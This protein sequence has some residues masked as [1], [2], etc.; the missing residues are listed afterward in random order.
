[1]RY[2][3]FGFHNLKKI[4]TSADTSFGCIFTVV[5]AVCINT[6]SSDAKSESASIVSGCSS[7]ADAVTSFFGFLPLFVL[8]CQWRTFQGINHGDAH[9]IS[10]NGRAVCHVD[11]LWI[12]CLALSI[13]FNFLV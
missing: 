13:Y 12:D 8:V 2:K 11:N 7:V 9:S 1:M 4:L 5:L 10:H 6:F 3:F